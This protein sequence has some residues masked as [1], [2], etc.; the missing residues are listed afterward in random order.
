MLTRVDMER[1]KRETGFNME[2]M[3]KVYHMQ[4]ILSKLIRNKT[5]RDNLL[6]KGGTSLN[7]F[8]LDI[9]RLS[10]DLDFNFIGTIEKEGMREL[11]HQIS[12]A[13][14]Q[15]GS[16]MGY[17][18]RNKGSSYIISRHI[19][20]F[21]KLSGII[22]HVKVEINYIQRLPVSEVQIGKM[23]VLFNDLDPI[24][25]QTYIIEEMLAQKAAACLDR[26]LPR[27]IFDLFMISNMSF[28]M[29][30]A[31]K[32]CATYFCMG[33]SSIDV[34]LSFF[35]EIDMGSMEN[36]LKQFIRTEYETDLED[37]ID[38]SKKFMEDLFD[39]DSVS[40]KFIERFYEEGVIDSDL[41]FPE[42]PDLGSHPSLLYRLEKIKK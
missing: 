30:L 2:L 6:L 11:R 10:I 40:S 32:L 17:E 14:E 21:R 38:I 4:S 36:E 29:D 28:D 8:H 1:K 22:D 33:S 19:F 23:H 42:G 39:F 15:I 26:Y 20:R 34:D 16:D 37:I 3:E 13:I 41:I 35:D 12:E 9:P 18:V 27:D 7:F 5:I 25:I 24:V 31:R